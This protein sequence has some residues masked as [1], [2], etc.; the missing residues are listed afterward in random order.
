MREQIKLAPME[1]RHLAQ[2]MVIEKDS[3][4]TPWSERTYF[5]EIKANQFATYHVAL[6]GEAVIGYAGYWLILDEA[7][8]TNIA[9]APKWRRQ[10]VARRLL[11]QLF[12]SATEKGACQATLEVRQS[13]TGAQTL[14]A[15]FGFVAAGLRR[16]YYTDNKE[17][18]LIMWQND[19]AAFLAGKEGAYG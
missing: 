4:I 15:E 5:Q 14:Y 19:I 9:V 13:N 7:H 3:F 8:I 12:V 16:A 6:V 1:P 2:V 17:N 10:G 18:A 11:H